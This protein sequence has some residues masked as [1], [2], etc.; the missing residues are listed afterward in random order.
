MSFIVRVE[1]QSPAVPALM[2]DA[3]RSAKTVQGD[4]DPSARTGE[5]N[6]LNEND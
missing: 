3:S 6:L 2:L 1:F 4:Y 5:T